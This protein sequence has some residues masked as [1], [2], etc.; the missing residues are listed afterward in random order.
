MINRKRSLVLSGGGSRGAWQVGALKALIEQGYSWDT[1]HGVSVGAL[2]G[3][4]LAMTPKNKLKEELPKLLKIWNEIE[5]SNDIYTPWSKIKGINYLCSMF[6]GSLNSGKPLRKIVEENF[7]RDAL[8]ESGTILTVGCCSLTSGQY[9]TID[10]SSNNIL[11][12]ILAS[13]HLP[14]VFE[15]LVVD[16]EQWVDGGIRHQIP[17]LEALRENP[18]EI[19]IVLT[20]PVAEERVNPNDTVL[21]SCPRVALRAS[22]ILADQVYINDYFTVSRVIKHN[23]V[24]VR[25]FVPKES[26]NI[27]SMNFD[28]E[29]IKLSIESGYRATLED[30]END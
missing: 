12:Y 23:K 13:S 9:V 7:S 17:I 26:L 19:D 8:Q 27:N 11:E 25:V 28:G 20:S 4:F 29:L 22:E 30:L 24:K 1:I 16:G 21:K 18:S 15:P 2:N 6:Y 5:S 14:L 3:S 10:S